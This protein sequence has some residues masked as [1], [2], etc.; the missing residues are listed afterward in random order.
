MQNKDIVAKEKKLISGCGHENCYA[1][2]PKKYI[3]F[4]LIL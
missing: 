4:V 1:S 2:N 3:F